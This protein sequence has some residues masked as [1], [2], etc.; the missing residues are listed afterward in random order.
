MITNVEVFVVHMDLILLLQVKAS[1]EQNVGAKMELLLF[2][3]AIRMDLTSMFVQTI[4]HLPVQSHVDN[5]YV[6]ICQMEREQLLQLDQHV[7][8]ITQ[9]TLISVANMEAVTVPVFHRTPSI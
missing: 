8:H 2:T 6:F 3:G 1:S 5:K 7:L 4:S 9:L